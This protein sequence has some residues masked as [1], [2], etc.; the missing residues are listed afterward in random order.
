MKESENMKL[1]L[2]IE[3]NKADFVL[4]LLKNLK[5]VKVKTISPYKAEVL[6]SIKQS[7]N[8]LKLIQEGKIKTIPARELLDEL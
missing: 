3:D 2:D 7:V 5:F 8:E 6:E 1:I 4:E